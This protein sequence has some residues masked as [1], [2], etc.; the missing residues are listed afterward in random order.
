VVTSSPKTETPSATGKN[1]PAT[2]EKTI[3]QLQAVQVGFSRAVSHLSE[4][5][6]T[7]ANQLATL[8]EEI[9]ERR[10]QLATLHDLTEVDDTTLDTLLATY[11][12]QEKTLG[13]ELRDRTETL[14]QEFMAL[15]QAWQKEQEEHARQLKD[16]N[17][18]AR[19]SRDRDSQE[20]R[21]ALQLE[22][23]LDTETYQQ[24][25][26]A[27][28]L[29][30]AEALQAQQKIWEERESAIADQEKAHAEAKAKVE[31]FP[32]ELEKNKKNGTDNGRNIGTYNAKVRADLRQKEIEG[33]R[34]NYTLRIGA[35]EST[36][37]TQTQRIQAL[38]AQVTAA[39]KQVQDLAVKAIEGASNRNELENMKAIALEQAKNQPKGGR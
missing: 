24:T 1:P 22:R 33:E 27:Q 18:T 29:A 21:Y 17:E 12:E 7:E 16:R 32:D 6:L 28:E 2:I 35:L 34:R 14:E 5:L 19:K 26:Q 10:S 36:I 9:A 37:H 11:D 13:A 20:Y 3:A 23:T 15:A 4:Q 30:L 8:Q 39:Q 31:A 38:T 25:C